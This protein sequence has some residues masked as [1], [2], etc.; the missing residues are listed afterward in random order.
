MRQSFGAE[1]RLKAK[2]STPRKRC[3]TYKKEKWPTTEAISL[4]LILVG[5]LVR[6]RPFLFV[7]QNL[8]GLRVHANFLRHAAALNVEGIA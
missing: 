4:A 3:V 2:A 5:G 7:F 8:A 1:I 6:V